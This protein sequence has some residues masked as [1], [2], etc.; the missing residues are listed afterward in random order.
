MKHEFIL[1]LDQLRKECGFPFII[2]SGYR[3]PDHPVEAKKSSP[4]THAMGIAADIAI[5]GGWQ[6]FKVVDEALALG[7]TGIGVGEDF[8]HVDTRQYPMMWVYGS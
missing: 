6:R 1:K 4:G 8:V 3:S 7:F 5:R 2:T